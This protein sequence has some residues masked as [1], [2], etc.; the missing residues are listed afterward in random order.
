[1]NSKFKNTIVGGI[2]NSHVI[3]F[4]IL[5]VDVLVKSMLRQGTP[6]QRYVLELVVLDSQEQPFNNHVDNGTVFSIN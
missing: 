6:F 3:S 4:V 2:P 1:M 5:A